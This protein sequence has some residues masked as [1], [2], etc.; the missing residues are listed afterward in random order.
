M[1]NAPM[2]ACVLRRYSVALI[3]Q[4]RSRGG[5]S[6]HGRG[7]MPVHGKISAH[8]KPL[9]VRMASMRSETLA[10]KSPLS[11]GK[12]H[13]CPALRIFRNELG[14]TVCLSRKMEAMRMYGAGYGLPPVY[15]VE[16][17][18]FHVIPRFAEGSGSTKICK[19]LLICLV[20]GTGGFLGSGLLH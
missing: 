3:P 1:G 18:P 13:R 6:A 19:G 20:A 12:F 2:H 11:P 14:Y 10:M 15:R 5:A 8:R 7:S 4:T 9:S 17:A 16:G